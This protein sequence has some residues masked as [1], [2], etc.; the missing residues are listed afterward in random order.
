MKFR[1]RNDVTVNGVRQGF[2][3]RDS[4]QLRKWHN[5]SSNPPVQ[6]LS[7][8]DLEYEPEERAYFCAM[9]K[10]KLEYIKNLQVWNCTE[11]SSYYDT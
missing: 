8:E 10:G 4:Y 9:C 11:C 3:D 1:K 6:I 7:Y 2:K 5:P